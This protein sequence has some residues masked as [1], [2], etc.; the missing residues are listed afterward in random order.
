MILI[1]VNTSTKTRGIGAGRATDMTAFESVVREIATHASPGTILVEKSTV[2]CKTGQLIKDLMEAHRPG[3]VFP[4]LSNPEFLSEG[5][6][7]RDLM[8]PDRVIIGCE[9]TLS[10][11]K[12]AAALVDLYAAWVPRSKIAP[13]NIWS[14]ELCKLVANAMLAQRISSINSISAVCE[15]VGADVGEI[16]SSIG[17][18]P[19]IGELLR[20]VLP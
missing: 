9:S 1:S 13:I 5:T 4:V 15:K 18:D 17:M 7:V 14:S 11:Y 10:G 8:Q 20:N 19:R 16:A 6:A 3:I 12:A 2:P